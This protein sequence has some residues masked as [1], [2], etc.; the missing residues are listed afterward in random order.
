MPPKV[1]RVAS[2]KGDVALG[3]KPKSLG[4]RAQEALSRPG[5]ASRLHPQ[6]MPSSPRYPTMLAEDWW[7]RTP[8]AAAAPTLEKLRPH[9]ASIDRPPPTLVSL[10]STCWPDMAVTLTPGM[11]ADELAAE[12]RER[13]M[14]GPSCDFRFSTNGITLGPDSI[15]EQSGA[16]ARGAGPSAAAAA[17]AAP[18]RMEMVRVDADPERGL[19][20][21]RITSHLLKTRSLVVEPTTTVGQLKLQIEAAL[22]C[23]APHPHRSNP[24]HL[25]S[26]A[27]TS[28]AGRSGPHTWYNA[29]GEKLRLD[30]AT[31]LVRAAQAEEVVAKGA[32]LGAVK[33]GEEL[34]V[35]PLDNGGGKGKKKGGG[36][37][38]PG[39]AFQ[40]F[41]PEQALPSFHPVFCESRAHAPSHPLALT[42]ARRAESGVLV[43]VAEDNAVPLAPSLPP[44]E[45]RLLFEGLPMPT[46]DPELSLWALGVRTDDHLCLSFDSPVIPDK[47][48]LVRTPAPPKAPKGDKKGGKGKGKGKKKK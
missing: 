41:A 36:L 35:C 30:G 27:P 16:G 26:C 7:T 14:L 19:E 12:L 8:L 31:W 38:A 29:N 4:E 1:N 32:G 48:R 9:S 43:Q 3:K 21:V 23:A 25:L 46:D 22:K 20:R 40:R 33:Q 42:A 17:R 2:M 24:P 5:T 13:L 28:L 47:L 44:A 39:G 15:V 11:R 10:R 18:L 6:I 34:V 37:G 45:Q